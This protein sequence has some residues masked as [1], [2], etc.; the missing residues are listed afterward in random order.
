MKRVVSLVCFGLILLGCL[1][2]APAANAGE[3]APAAHQKLVSES[4]EYL[5]D[6]STLV[7]AVYEVV[8]N[9][10]I[11][12]SNKNGSKVYTRRDADGNALWTFT[13]SGEF[14]IIDGVSVTCT[15]ATCSAN[16]LESTWSCTRQFA[17]RSGSQAVAEGTFILKLLGIT[18][19]EENVDIAL[20]CDVYG[21]LS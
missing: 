3:I 9:S 19:K 1:I 7:T 14:L 17:E 13:V 6:G 5:D 11:N 15:S 20:S 10:R 4:V 21:N 2:A 18:V 12:T 16:I 8:N